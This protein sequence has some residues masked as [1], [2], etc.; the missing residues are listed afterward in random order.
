MK[1]SDLKELIREEID[2]M[3]VFNENRKIVEAFDTL[4]SHLSTSQQKNKLSSDAIQ[5]LS[6]VRDEIYKLPR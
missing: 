4:V 2:S 3:I 1:K 5:A 6:V